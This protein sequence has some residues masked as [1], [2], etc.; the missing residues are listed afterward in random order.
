MTF[1]QEPVSP[2]IASAAW[3]GLT[4]PARIAAAALTT[5][6]AKLTGSQRLKDSAARQVASGAEA[7]AKGALFYSRGQSIAFNI[8]FATTPVAALF[9]A[10]AIAH[11]VLTTEPA[12]SPAAQRPAPAASAPR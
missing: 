3:N 6:A 2:S 11:A 9:A 5:V 7:M 8:G 1:S 4:Q 10:G 12:A